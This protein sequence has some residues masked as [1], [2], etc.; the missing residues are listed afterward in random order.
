MGLFSWYPFIRRKGYTLAQLYQSVLTSITASGRRRLDVLGSCYKVIRNSYSNMPQGVAHRSL[1]KE[2]SLFR[3][4][5]N[6]TLYI[7][8][9]PAKE[10]AETA[11]ERQK[12]REK[13]LENT[14]DAN[15]RDII[16]C[17]SGMLAYE[18]IAT[19]WRPV[20]NGMILVYSIPG[21]LL[22]L[23]ITA[24]AVASRADYNK[25]IRT[26]HEFPFIKSIDSVD[27]RKVVYGYLA[28]TRVISKNKDKKEFEVS[29]RVF[30][31]KRQTKL[32]RVDSTLDAQI[33][34]EH[35]RL[36]FKNLYTRH[37][38]LKRV[39][40]AAV[41]LTTTVAGSD[42]HL[43]EIRDV[44]K[45]KGDIDKLWLGKNVDDMK[46]VTL[47]RRQ[48][49]VVGGFAHMP[50]DLNEE[51]KGK[52][53]AIGGLCV[54]GVV[55]SCQE[56]TAE[57]MTDPS[58]APD[59]VS[60][61]VHD[62]VTDPR[63]D[64][65]KPPFYN[66]A[67]KQKAFY[68]PLFRHRRWLENEKAVIPEDEE[69]SV[70]DIES[71]LPPPKG[72]SASV[73]NYLEELGL[74][75]TRLKNIYAGNDNRYKKHEWDLERAKH[76]EYQ[77][78]AERLPNVVGGSLGRRIEDNKDKDSILSRVGLSQLSSNSKLSSLHSTFLSYFIGTVSLCHRRF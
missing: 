39:V 24:L 20:S 63:G 4:V 9:D 56:A 31:D 57:L 64:S 65:S 7:D 67:V 15:S 44:V 52:E 30:I 6:M 60:T 46:I 71:R 41:T 58:P 1:E 68:Q 53:I 10:K 40:V 38:E 35:L 37:N 32:D 21:L 73:I 8:G 54:E 55:M 66:L 18:S 42:Y 78:L 77:A 70:A 74:V 14:I 19:L 26:G 34:Y 28:N 17:D 51:G 27:P 45:S 69:E 76:A 47:D 13:A 23:G 62:P 43:S 16:I 5:L 29:I 33:L 22:A 59:L 49:C 3:T 50:K 48:V 61:P 2:V 36:H 25:N 12:R 72:Q 11:A 75:E